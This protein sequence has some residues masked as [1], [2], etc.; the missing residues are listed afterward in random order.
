MDKN[1]LI[2]DIFAQALFLRYY[3]FTTSKEESKEVKIMYHVYIR[4][5]LAVVWFAAAIISGSALY[6]IMGCAF[7]YSTYATWKKEKDDKGGM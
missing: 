2:V 4:G 3:I 1:L 7:L 6:V 5:I